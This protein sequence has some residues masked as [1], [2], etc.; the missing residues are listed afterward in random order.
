MLPLQKGDP[1]TFAHAPESQEIRLSAVRRL[2]KYAALLLLFA[3]ASAP[4]LRADRERAQLSDWKPL[5]ALAD[6]V[7]E[8]GDRNRAR[9]L[10]ARIG[11]IGSSNQDWQALLAAACGFTRIDGAPTR[12]SVSYALLIRATFLAEQHKSRRAM[13]TIVKAFTIMGQ[14]KT[15]SIFLAR[16]RGDWPPD[17]AEPIEFPLRACL[18][19][20]VR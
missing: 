8:K 19:A 5:A 12:Y 16:M 17:K 15:A 1:V 7:L 10:Y 14:P 18:A 11:E 9:V 4:W 2:L 6:L 3:I 13:I 20:K